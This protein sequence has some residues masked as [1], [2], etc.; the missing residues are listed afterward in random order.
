MA[1]VCEAYG[2]EEDALKLPLRRRDIAEARALIALIV[3]G[4]GH[5]KLV[6]LAEYL[7]KDISGLSQG[8]RRVGERMIVDEVLRD[9]LRE[10]REGLDGVGPE[11]ITQTSQA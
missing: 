3:L 11:E 6:E 10:V 8:A 4:T 1:R 2:I 9:R 7:D 5:L